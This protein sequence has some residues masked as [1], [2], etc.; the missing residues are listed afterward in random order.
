MKR[1]RYLSLRWKAFFFTSSVLGLVFSAITAINHHTIEDQYH[2]Q[3]EHLLVE[4]IRETE[5]IIG[6]NALLL[7]SLAQTFLNFD[8]MLRA[9]KSSNSEAL[10]KSFD[11]HWWPFQLSNGLKHAVF[12]S[13]ENSA[14]AEWGNGKEKMHLVSDSNANGRSHH[15]LHCD[16][17]C[18]LYTTVPLHHQGEL[19][20]T[21]LLG[22]NLSQSL[23]DFRR[24]MDVDIGIVTSQKAADFRQ[25]LPKWDLASLAITV[26]DKNI[27]LITRMSGSITPDLDIESQAILYSEDDKTYELALTQITQLSQTNKTYWLFI[28]DVS[29]LVDSK[30]SALRNNIILALFGL[31]VSSGL[32]L[33]VSWRPLS[34]LTQITEELPD[35]VSQHRTF[36]Q[37]HKSDLYRRRLLYDESDVV[38]SS[39]IRLAKRLKVLNENIQTRT[40]ELEDN[41]IKLE[42]EKAFTDALLDT[43]Q[44]LIITQDNKGNILLVNHYAQ[45]VSGYS[46][47]ELEGKQ[48]SF[49]F[50]EDENISTVETILEQIRLGKSSHGRHHTDLKTIHGDLH[51][52][53]WYHSKLDIL[54]SEHKII[55]VALD[56]SDKKRIEENLG[57]LA[58][59]DP[60]TGL[61]NRRRFTE[62]VEQVISASHRYDH[63]SALLF[64]DM[65]NFKDVN[66]LSGHHAGDELLTRVADV[67]REQSRESDTLA[68]LGGDEFAVILKETNPEDAMVSAKR[69]CRALNEIQLQVGP[70]THQVSSSIGIAMYPEHGTD[71]KSLLAHADMA[72]YKAKEDGRNRV[73]M[74]SEKESSPSQVKQRVFWNKKAAE[75]IQNG[76][77]LMYYQPIWDIQK[78]HISHYEALLRIKDGEDIYPPMNLI[79]AAERNNIIYEIDALVLNQVFKDLSRLEERGISAHFNI[80]ISGLSFQNTNLVTRICDLIT[81]YQINPSQL[82]FE[83]TETAAV[84]DVAITSQV[85]HE[86]K[87]LGIQIA[88]D[89]FGV[90]FSS[91]YYLK[92]FPIDFIKIDGSF[93]KN[94]HHDKDSQILVKA[95][96]Q[97]AK[98]FNQKTVAE[99]VESEEILEKL[100][101]LGVD[102]AQGFHIKH[103]APLSDLLGNLDV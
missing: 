51:H 36:L 84:A 64:F 28:S 96:V 16:N 70:H 77:V 65:D 90:G 20:G 15:Y 17:N 98:S 7:Q 33:L 71:L 50:S 62:E 19:L 14:L 68:R 38:R 78:R 61:F 30:Q 11:P 58:N 75:L 39:A 9:L 45:W 56:I 59:N 76:E 42:A 27:P 88:L 1:K 55:T 99:F 13:K 25:Y 34:R 40:Q 12:Y 21:V 102:Y 94:I 86:L 57:V 37:R 47:K 3:R 100:K 31:I 60:L 67:L 87:G 10:K 22:A 63:K 49:L 5:L 83:I 48:L 91:I 103:P 93:I 32:G 66:D 4:Y 69:F 24:R 18:T 26:P 92:H 2:Q 97:V 23:I 89:D 79:N 35:L 85:M 6:Q 53:A 80:N 73:T 54:N 46:S 44:A 43:A 52:M 82:T 81:Q 41:A 101:K 95:I 74:Y 8:G 29:K 72:M